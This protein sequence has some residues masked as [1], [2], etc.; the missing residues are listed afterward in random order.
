MTETEKNYWHLLVKLGNE[1]EELREELAVIHWFMGQRID[2]D[3][4]QTVLDRYYTDKNWIIRAR[5]EEEE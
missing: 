2:F 5:N 4:E 1:N 3:G